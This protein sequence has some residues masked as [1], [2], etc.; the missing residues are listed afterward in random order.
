MDSLTQ[1]VLGAAVGDVAAGKK[2]GTKAMLWGAVGGT[3]PDLDV[4]LNFFYDEPE[5]L[6][7]HRG[8]SHSVFFAF[9]VAPVLGW[10]LGKLD[11]ALTTRE[12][13]TVFFWSIFTHPLLDIFTGYGTGLFVPVW[14][15]RIQ[16]DTIF[17][18]DP[19]FTLPLL[20][21][22]V[23]L[24][25]RSKP[26]SRRKKLSGVAL[27]IS[28]CYLLATVMVKLWVAG[29]VNAEIE[30][31]NIAAEQKMIA[32]A[33]F[34]T[35]LWSVIIK[36]GDHFLVGYYSLFDKQGIRFKEIESNHGMLGAVAGYRETQMLASFAK[37]F[38]AIERQGVNFIWKDLRFGTSKG[39]FDVDA[40]YIFMFRLTPQRNSLDVE[41]VSPSGNIEKEDLSRLLH[42]TFGN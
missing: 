33:A 22:F 6:L 13:T 20:V 25:I 14:D 11:K 2:A 40:D 7:M 9:L 35:F 5:S 34:T 31:Q 39:W 8:F 1:F 37:G 4:L 36:E 24:L 28:T 12:W 32:P 3:I 17:I 16:F 27:T 29:K 21:S 15:Y 10:L 19:L 26:L 42:R 23:W 18:I 41:R 38:F 30:R